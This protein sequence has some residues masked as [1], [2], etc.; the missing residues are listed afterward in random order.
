MSK[1]YHVNFADRMGA[2]LF[3]ALLRAGIKIGTMALLTVRG[4][5]SGQPHT[6]LVLLVE[7][8]GVIT[9]IHIAQA[10]DTGQAKAPALSDAPDDAGLPP[11]R[12]V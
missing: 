6:V 10:R 3:I 4:R 5:K 8:D 11:S 9:S 2:A 7:Q 12:K 1:T